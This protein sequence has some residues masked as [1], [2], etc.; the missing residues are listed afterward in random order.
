MKKWIILVLTL[1]ALT[2]CAEKTFETVTDTVEH[3][4]M[5]QQRQVVLQLPAEAVTP[6]IQSE[7]AGALYLCDGYTMTLH[8]VQAGDIEN[9]FR[10]TTGFSKDALTVLEYRQGDQKRYECVWTCA[11]EGTDQIGKAAIISDGAYHYVL[12]VM[13]D[14]DTAGALWETWKTLF[15]SFQTVSADTVLNTGS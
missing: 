7:Q 13:A 12:S 3:Q 2:G 4:Q 15:A 9:T 14:A 11:G 5:P 10:Q 8:T 6:T 1:L